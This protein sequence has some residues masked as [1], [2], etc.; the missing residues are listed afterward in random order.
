MAGRGKITAMNNYIELIDFSLGTFAK[1]P[2]AE[3]IELLGGL[4]A[5]RC[6]PETHWPLFWKTFYELSMTPDHPC[7]RNVIAQ[8]LIQAYHRL[9]PEQQYEICDFEFAARMQTALGWWVADWQK[10]VLKHIVNI[11]AQIWDFQAARVREKENI[12]LEYK[13]SVRARRKCKTKTTEQ[14]TL[15]VSR[16]E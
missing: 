10:Q 3:K 6:S 5:G 8:T 16:T 14:L 13:D 9:T 1:T 4:A 2:L 7:D 11:P 15:A 12:E